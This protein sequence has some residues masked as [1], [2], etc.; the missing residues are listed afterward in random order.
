MYAGQPERN[1]VATVGSR[2][3]AVGYVHDGCASHGAREGV[4]R[5]S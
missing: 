2:T 4:A 5:T 1:P 3:L